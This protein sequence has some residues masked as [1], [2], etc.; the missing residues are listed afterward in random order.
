M[1]LKEDIASYFLP[2]LKDIGDNEHVFFRNIK[3]D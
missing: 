3:N 2:L 1:E